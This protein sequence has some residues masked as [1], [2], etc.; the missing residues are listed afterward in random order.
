[1]EFSGKQKVRGTYQKSL[2]HA[3]HEFSVLLFLPVTFGS[4]IWLESLRAL[5]NWSFEVAHCFLLCRKLND[6]RREKHIQFLPA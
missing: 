5:T 1:M 4:R 2:R 3:L 6:A